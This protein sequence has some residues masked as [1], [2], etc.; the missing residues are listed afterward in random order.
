MKKLSEIFTIL[1]RKV[2]VTIFRPNP[3]KYPIVFSG[4]NMLQ[5][6]LS[7]FKMP[8]KNDN[9]IY[10]C[11]SNN[12]VAI[13]DLRC[14]PLTFDFAYS[15]YHAECYFRDKGFNYFDLFIVSLFPPK[16]VDQY[17]FFSD[18]VRLANILLPLAYS[19]QFCRSISV[20]DNA[21][22]IRNICVNS[23]HI[24]PPH[25]DGLFLR[26]FSYKE[27]FENARKNTYFSG[28][29]ATKADLDVVSKWLRGSSINEKF[30]TFTVRNRKNHA[31]NSNLEVYKDFSKYLRTIN[32]SCVFIPDTENPVLDVDEQDHIF[33][34]ASF[35]IFQRMAIYELALLNI[36]SN[37]GPYS[38]CVLDNSCNYIVSGIFN[39]KDPY[40]DSSYF[41]D[42]G[43][44]YGEQPFQHD[45]GVWI[46]ESAS[47]T[48]LK[49]A[50]KK[51]V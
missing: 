14:S 22:L 7:N 2:N 12:P 15:L 35:N 48:S 3:I 19:Y 26:H 34:P 50:F 17:R 47:L 20:I 39:E 23:N 11:Y 37:N 9:N 44:I 6:F 25:Y 10:S 46:W 45:R 13:Y 36:F 21:S 1:T 33:N 43:L 5:T 40:A 30:V 42:V 24:F 18:K 29:K 49:D 27:V 16:E 8:E 32:I 51:F 28:F 31:R 4:S 38:I 41:K